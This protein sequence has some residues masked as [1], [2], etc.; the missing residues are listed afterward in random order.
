[1]MQFIWIMDKTLQNAVGHH[2]FRKITT[3][4]KV[5][6]L[7]LSLPQP[8]FLL[9]VIR[10]PEE[11]VNSN[12]KV[13]QA[14]KPGIRSL[15]TRSPRYLSEQFLV[16]GPTPPERDKTHNLTVHVGLSSLELP[17]I[18]PNQEQFWPPQ[19][20]GGDGA[21]STALLNSMC[22]VSDKEIIFPSGLFIMCKE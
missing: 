21:S 9:C 4:Q 18:D 1:M 10:Y 22:C 7:C 3:T 15:G 2:F 5:A 16:A 11:D 20:K 17:C 13:P 8:H 19:E 6:N 14:L 12:E